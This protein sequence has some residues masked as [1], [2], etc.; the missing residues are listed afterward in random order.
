[1]VVD[2]CRPYQYLGKRS[3]FSSIVTNF[4]TEIL[5]RCT[6]FGLQF[7]QILHFK[8]KLNFIS[9][10]VVTYSHLHSLK[11]HSSNTSKTEK[12]YFLKFWNLWNE[13]RVT[14]TFSF[15]CFQGHIDHSD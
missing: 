15:N 14:K 12:K 11:K 7:L 6:T 10:D 3:H 9:W 4:H 5:F 13:K 2:V 1:M 8:K